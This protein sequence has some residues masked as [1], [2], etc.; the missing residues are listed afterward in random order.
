MGVKIVRLT[1]KSEGLASLDDLTDRLISSGS[2]SKT[3]KDDVKGRSGSRVDVLGVV[4]NV[5]Q[6][7]CSICSVL[8]FWNLI[9]EFLRRTCSRQTKVFLGLHTPKNSSDFVGP[10]SK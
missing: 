4:G 5:L 7:A 2:K 3:T 10:P 1:I 8:I 6:L 9:L